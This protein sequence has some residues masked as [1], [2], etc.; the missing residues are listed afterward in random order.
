[1]PYE[2]IFV[3]EMIV[4]PPGAEISAFLISI[5]SPMR[6]SLLSL[7]AATAM[8]ESELPG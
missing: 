8:T 4:A 7:I 5:G 2:F 3:V 1:M 6:L